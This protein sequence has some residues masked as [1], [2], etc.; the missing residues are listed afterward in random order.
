MVIVLQNDTFWCLLQGLSLR[1]GCWNLKIL[2]GWIYFFLFKNFLCCGL[3]L[4]V[5]SKGKGFLE[6]KGNNKKQKINESCSKHF[7]GCNN[8]H[9]QKARTFDIKQKIMYDLE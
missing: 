3:D 4:A 7:R 8:Q 2:S 1:F 9:V 6:G 5:I